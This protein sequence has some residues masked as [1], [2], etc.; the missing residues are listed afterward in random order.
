MD[1]QDFS[2]TFRIR[3]PHIDPAELSRQLGIEPEHAWRAGEPRRPEPGE[4][5]RS[6]VYRETYWVGELQG[7]QPWGAG[8][9][10]DHPPG[11]IGPIIAAVKTGPVLPQITLYFTLLKMKRA[12][13]F[14]RELTEQGGTIECL[15]QVHKTEGFQLEIS[16][17]LMLM[18]V[19]LKV[20]LS[21]EVDG[22]SH[23]EEQAA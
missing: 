19:E 18:L 17:A 2:V 14:W 9:L 7:P 12:G 3:H 15:L 13:A 16:Q 20:A 10:P 22:T 21:I 6:G 23:A 4:A 1:P 11:R 5:A 8:M